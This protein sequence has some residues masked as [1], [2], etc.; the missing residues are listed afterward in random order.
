MEFRH[1]KRSRF[2]LSRVARV[3]RGALRRVLRRQLNHPL[4]F[5]RLRRRR[6]R[7]HGFAHRA[8]LALHLARLAIRLRARARR[9]VRR[10]RRPPPRSSRPPFAKLRAAPRARRSSPAACVPAS[11]RSP[12]AVSHPYRTYPRTRQPPPR[13]R[14]RRR[15]RRPP[16]PPFAFLLAAAFVARSTSRNASPACAST[17][18]SASRSFTAQFPAS[19]APS[20]RRAPVHR[21]SSSSSLRAS[22]VP[23]FRLARR[24]RERVRDLAKRARDAVDLPRRPHR[25][26]ASRCVDARFRSTVTRADARASTRRHRATRTRANADDDERGRRTLKDARDARGAASHGARGARVR[27]VRDVRAR[28]GGRSDDGRQGARDDGRRSRDGSD[29]RGRC[30]T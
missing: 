16:S 27:R 24:L 18:S 10:L 26:V 13:P 15:R 28:D 4:R 14:R 30:D 11:A 3:L 22:R 19:V 20:P 25:V 8:S 6:R 7:D 29:R 1:A 21:R 23:R 9:I 2:E 12:A 5:F 17:R